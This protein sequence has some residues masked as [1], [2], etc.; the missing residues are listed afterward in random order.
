MIPHFDKP[1]KDLLKRLKIFLIISPKNLYLTYK[2]ELS[3]ENFFYL[4]FL[5][6]FMVLNQKMNLLFYFNTMFWQIKTKKHSKNASPLEISNFFHF[7]LIW[8][9]QVQQL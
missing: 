3:P 5:F 7:S 1:R 6:Y 8:K 4:M 2:D 9:L